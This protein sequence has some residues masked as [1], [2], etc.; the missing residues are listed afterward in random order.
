MLIR[1]ND[2][3]LR[4][5]EDAELT[6]AELEEDDC[7]KDLIA[8]R[9]TYDESNKTNNHVPSGFSSCIS[10]SDEVVCLH[11]DFEYVKVPKRH[12]IES[13]KAKKRLKA[14]CRKWEA[15]CSIND[16]EVKI[17]KTMKSDLE[18]I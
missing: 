17:L 18:N 15:K 11:C 2:L 8:N 6:D 1:L 5:G 14:S 4:T 12:C 10:D 7:S 3:I 9:A 13:E 16:M